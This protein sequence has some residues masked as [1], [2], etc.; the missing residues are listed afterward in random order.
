M[1]DEHAARPP[2]NAADWLLEYKMKDLIRKAVYC[3]CCELDEDLIGDIAE[4]LVS[5]YPPNEPVEDEAAA[6]L[7]Q[8][9]RANELYIF[10]KWM[11][12]NRKGRRIKPI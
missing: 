2:A 6:R 9:N 10:G 3:G 7:E 12:T 11:Q 5:M 1:T 8:E 4:Y